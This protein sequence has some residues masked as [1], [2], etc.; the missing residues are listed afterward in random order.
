VLHRK[1]K[2]EV[3]GKRLKNQGKYKSR[4]EAEDAYIYGT[5]RKVEEA[6][7]GGHF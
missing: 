2:K 3:K 7:R 5:L 4:E 6:K 1:L